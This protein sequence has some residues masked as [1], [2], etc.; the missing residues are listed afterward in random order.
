MAR[1]ES[2]GVTFITKSVLRERGW[3]PKMVSQLLGDPDHWA[4]D[5]QWGSLAALF[6][7][8]RVESLESSDAFRAAQRA[9]RTRRAAVAIDLLE[10]CG[11]R[12]LGQVREWLERK[13]R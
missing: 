8:E 9:S 7:L 11:P 4:R 3:S 1:M 2:A 12:D 10:Q 5:P 6:D 13:T